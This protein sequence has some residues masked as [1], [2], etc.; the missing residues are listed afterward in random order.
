VAAYSIDHLLDLAE[1]SPAGRREG[2]EYYRV[3]RVLRRAFWQIGQW[4][5][6]GG[7]I[8][9]YGAIRLGAVI[10]SMLADLEGK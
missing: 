5:T 2:R 4:L 6:H 8:D 3:R 9:T 7:Q 1:R 10:D